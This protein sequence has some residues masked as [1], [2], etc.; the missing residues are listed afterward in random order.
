MKCILVD[1]S[2]CS[3]TRFAWRACLHQSNI[4]YAD[5]GAIWRRESSQ[6]TGFEATGRGL[7]YMLK[8]KVFSVPLVSDWCILINAINS[9]SYKGVEHPLLPWIDRIRTHCIQFTVK[10]IWNPHFTFLIPD[11]LVKVVSKTAFSKC[12]ESLDGALNL[13]ISFLLFEIHVLPGKNTSLNRA[14][15]KYEVFFW[16]TMDYYIVSTVVGIE[17]SVYMSQTSQISC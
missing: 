3:K 12:N 1:R 16:R 17:I 9:S 11:R 7:I 5:Y 10:I 2:F 6:Q 4:I 14:T 15:V 8:N 13:L